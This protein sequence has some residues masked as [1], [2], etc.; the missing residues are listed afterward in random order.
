[1]RAHIAKLVAQDRKRP[2]L[3][4]RPPLIRLGYLL[5][6]EDPDETG[7]RAVCDYGV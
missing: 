4:R 6:S 5:V 2:A 3:W 7:S 1:M